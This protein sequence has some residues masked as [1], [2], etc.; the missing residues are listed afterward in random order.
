MGCSRACDDRG[1]I[2]LNVDPSVIVLGVA[3]G[4]QWTNTSNLFGQFHC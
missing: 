1:N 2:N 3:Y 4:D